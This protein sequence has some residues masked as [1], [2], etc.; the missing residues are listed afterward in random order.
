MSCR[1]IF[2]YL[3]SANR[4][5][6]EA[7]LYNLQYLPCSHI[8]NPL[9]N[10]YLLKHIFPRDSLLSNKC[11]CHNIAGILKVDVTTVRGEQ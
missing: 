7:N 9:H 11:T 4:F 3:I 5:A 1:A 10:A 8:R 6:M 2:A